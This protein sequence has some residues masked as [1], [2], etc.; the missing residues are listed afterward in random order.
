MRLMNY[1]TCSKVFQ[2]VLIGL[3]GIFLISPLGAQARLDLLL[4]GDLVDEGDP[5]DSNDY[6]TGGGSDT[7]NDICDTYTAPDVDG[8]PTVVRIFFGERIGSL[9]IPVFQSGI[10]MLQ[11][12]DFSRVDSAA[13]T[14]AQ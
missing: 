11:V 14:N 2:C 3:I 1:S 9:V 8:F 10:P 7:D 12:I 13:V 6:S 4:G 5:L